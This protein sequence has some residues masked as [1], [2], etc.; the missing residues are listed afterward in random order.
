MLRHLRMVGLSGR[1]P[2]GFTYYLYR[3]WICVRQAL[4]TP[5]S[6]SPTAE[7]R[8]DFQTLVQVSAAAYKPYLTDQLATVE[9]PA[10]IPD[11]V[12]AGKI[13]CLEGQ[14]EA[15]AVFERLLTVEAA[16]ALLGKEAFAAHS[17]DPSFWFCAAG[18]CA[19][20]V[21]LLPGARPQFPGSPSLSGV[22]S[23]VPPRMFPPADV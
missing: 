19:R 8:Q 18:A 4:G 23:P 14:E 21:R 3:Y 15:A 1:E 10:G 16:P 6:S 22:L 7:Q 2:P 11:E 5:V 9:F 20:S 13:D 12:L 17:Q